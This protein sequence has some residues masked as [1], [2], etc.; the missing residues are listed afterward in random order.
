[1]FDPDLKLLGEVSGLDDADN[2][3]IN[4]EGKLAYVGYGDG[5]LAIIDPHQIK[6]IGEV[7]LDGH[8]EAFQLALNSPRIFINVPTAHHI[9]VVDREKLAVTAKRPRRTSL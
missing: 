3:R 9:A 4:R 5:A 8:P 2:V 6:K 7:K 1:V